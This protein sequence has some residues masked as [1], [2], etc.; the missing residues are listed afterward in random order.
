MLCSS[1]FN[2]P[3]FFVRTFDHF[4]FHCVHLSF[5]L[6]IL[7]FFLFFCPFLFNFVQRLALWEK[8][9]WKKMCAHTHKS[10]KKKK[11]FAAFVSFPSPVFSQVRM[12]KFLFTYQQKQ[13][14]YTSISVFYRLLCFL[15][16]FF[17]SLLLL[18]CSCCCCRSR[19]CCCCCYSVCVL[20]LSVTR[21]T[22]VPFPRETISPTFDNICAVREGDKTLKK[23]FIPLNR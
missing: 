20:L 6:L 16:S 8:R 5:F 18:V 21:T 22:G 2:L 12:L 11:Y 15:C 3:L 9:R 23:Q 4:G 7:P 13:S 14:S 10:T 19:C 1:K 17:T